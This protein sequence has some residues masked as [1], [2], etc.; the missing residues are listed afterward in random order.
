[1]SNRSKFVVSV[2]LVV[3]M[4]LGACA[5]AATPTPQPKPPIK[6]AV[7]GPLT[8]DVATFGASNRDG[9]IMALEEWNAK[10][11]VLGSKIEWVLGD[12][13]CDPKAGADVAKKVI[14]EDKVKYIVGAVCSSESIPMT[15]YAGQKGV[16]QISGTSTNPMVTVDND[17]K[18]KPYIFRACFI[19]PFQGWVMATFALKNLGAKTAAVVLDVGNDYIKGLAEVFRDEFEKGGGKVVVWE[20]FVKE[21]T[22]FS[23]ILAKV[24]DA[25]PDV[26]FIPTYYDKVNLIAAQAKQKGITSALLGGDGWDSP[27]TDLAAVDGGYHSNHYHP[28]DTRAVAQDFRRRYE[29]KYGKTPDALAALGYDAAMLLVQAIANAGVDDPAKVKDALAAIKMECVSGMITFDQYHNPIKSAAI[30]HVKDGKVLF[31]ASVSP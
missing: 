23:A 28:D 31:E 16:V 26:F 27:D 17:G 7:V 19:D 15:E 12:S 30:L 14:D 2:L 4:L 11:G 5:P 10:G 29:A 25:N 13:Q 9:A 22:D 6:I 18:V 8:G 21:D 24:K 3:C 1:M 20:A